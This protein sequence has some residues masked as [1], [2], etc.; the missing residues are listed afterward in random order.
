VP[1]AAAASSNIADGSEV[2]PGTTRRNLVNRSLAALVLF[3]TACSTAPIDMNEPRRI[4]GTESAVRIDA[5]IR[6]E[7]VRPGAPIPFTYVI[8]NQRSEP[9]AVADIVPVSTYDTETQTITVD[10]GS[11]VPGLQLLPRLIPIAPGEKKTFSGSA[12]VSFAMQSR[13]ADPRTRFPA[14]LRL[15]LN[16]LGDTKPFAELLNIPEK[17]VADAKRA[18]ELFPVWVERNEVVYTN[19][20]PVR[21]VNAAEQQPIQP[22]P[23]PVRRGRRP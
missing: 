16:F 1:A 22:P 9:I 2:S 14:S 18:D 5:E 11:E 13:S 17:A 4:V 23:T 15:K 21:W 10:I 6:A 3:F 8:T 7:E 12:R 19:A 20:I